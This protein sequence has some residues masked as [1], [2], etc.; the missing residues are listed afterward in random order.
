MSIILVLPT[1]LYS[2]AML[3][4]RRQ[5]LSAGAR[6]LGATMLAAATR[7]TAAPRRFSWPDGKIGA[8]SL[9]YD[10]GLPSQ[11]DYAMPQLEAHGMRGTCFVTGNEIP[12]RDADWRTAAAR[13][14]EIADHTTNH[15]CDLRRFRPANFRARE[16]RPMEQYLDELAGVA[17]F[18][19]YAYP[20]DV[21]NL[22]IG[23]A[24]AQARRYARLLRSAGIVAARTSE[25]DPNDPTRCWRSAYRIH[26]L[27]VGYDAPD[28]IA[29]EA[30]LKL[31][32]D[33]GHWA[34]LIFHGLVQQVGKPGDTRIEDHRAILD[35]VRKRGPWC[36]PFGRVF[37]HIRSMS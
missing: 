29:V 20:C 14:H 1:G 34:I 6:S 4:G 22:D 8:V 31:A 18:R 12:G 30:Y 25:G 19:A 13:G 32:T 5:I 36:A 2:H 35:T 16:V 11:L 23:S 9:T 33:R 27:A 21:T 37:A 17:R 15:P 28:P 10:D 7:G 26:A 24:N 3:L